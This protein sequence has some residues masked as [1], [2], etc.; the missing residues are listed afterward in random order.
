MQNEGFQGVDCRSPETSCIVFTQPMTFR[1][2]PAW[3][4]ELPFTFFGWKGYRRRFRKLTKGAWGVYNHPC[5][6]FPEDL[7]AGDRCYFLYDGRVRGWMRIVG[8]V[9]STNP[10]VC[11]STQ[12]Q[13][14]AGCFLQT[15][16]SLNEIEDGQR[17]RLL[18]RGGVRP[19]TPE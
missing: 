17:L 15:A 11:S 6:K 13:M 10:W 3:L 5:S 2:E 18:G 4:L 16:G 8:H 12:K 14:P 19:F 1:G 9:Q 7:Q